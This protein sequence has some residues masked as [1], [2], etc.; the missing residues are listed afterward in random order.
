MFGGRMMWDT[1]SASCFKYILEYVFL[2]LKM[3][4]KNKHIA[5]TRH[6]SSVKHHNIPTCMEP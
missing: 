1:S 6:S 3:Q 4:V 2:R 5:L